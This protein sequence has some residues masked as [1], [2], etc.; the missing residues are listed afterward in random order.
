MSVIRKVE[1]G[2]RAAGRM[3]AGRASLLGR[4]ADGRGRRLGRR[5]GWPAGGLLVG[6]LLLATATLGCARCGAAGGEDAGG[7]DPAD[8]GASQPGRLVILGFDGVDP[9][10]LERWVEAGALPN[11]KR[12]MDRVGSTYRPL[13][14]TNPPQSPVAWTS[15]ATGTRPG[16]HGIFDFIGRRHAS[17]PAGPA[18]SPFPA[19]TS[20]EI[21]PVGP[22]VARNLRT[23]VPFWKLLGDAGIPVEAINIPY[24]FPPDPMREGRMLSGLGVPD[25]RETNSMFTYVGTEITPERARRSPG[26]GSLV[27]LTMEGGRG[28]FE[29]EGPTL[30]GERRRMRI[31]IEVRAGVPAEGFTLTV[32][33]QEVP[34]EPRQMSEFVELEFAEGGRRIKG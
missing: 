14:S 21:Q 9:R 2:W 26:G 12:L 18:V 27:P 5:H 34:L 20:F 24:S 19:T 25:L 15:F 4:D 29:L 13:G 33:A 32:G 30:P 6:A 28:R 11:V 7:V 1:A 23:G 8:P 3:A 17:G 10:W 31:P 16:E 22:P